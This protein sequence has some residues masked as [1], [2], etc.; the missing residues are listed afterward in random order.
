VIRFGRVVLVDAALANAGWR[1]DG[2]DL[3]PG[4]QLPAAPRGTPTLRER[5][6]GLVRTTAADPP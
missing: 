1:A 2:K 6:A 5:V 4:G 3:L